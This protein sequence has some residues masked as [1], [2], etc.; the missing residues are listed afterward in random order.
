MFFKIQAEASIRCENTWLFCKIKRWDKGKRRIS[1]EQGRPLVLF[2]PLLLLVRRQLLPWLTDC[3]GDGLRASLPS[4][5]AL[6]WD[7]GNR[8]PLLLNGNLL[9][10]PPGCEE[11]TEWWL[12]CK[13]FA[14]R[15]DG[16][17]DASQ[18][19]KRVLDQSRC[20]A[21]IRDSCN[22]SKLRLVESWMEDASHPSQ[23]EQ[24]KMAKLLQKVLFTF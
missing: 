13:G 12:L 21:V 23:R 1:P 17:C 14:G 15:D 18:C 11:M 6:P 8:L 4:P 16:H 7:C 5:S 9:R 22:S 19:F 20:Q 24:V 2:S 3:L 10:L